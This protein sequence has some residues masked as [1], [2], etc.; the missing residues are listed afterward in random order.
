MYHVVCRAGPP[1]SAGMR[2][3]FRCFLSTRD[4]LR[5]LD[6]LLRGTAQ[7]A[8]A[9]H[10][11]Y[12]TSMQAIATMTPLKSRPCSIPGAA[13]GEAVREAGRETW[14][15]ARMSQS[16]SLFMSCRGCQRVERSLRFVAP[17]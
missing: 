6:G 2:T 4:V 17:S 12:P 9:K 11:W 16:A 1:S 10:P 13:A 3:R 14:T 5:P 8:K 7:L 15:K